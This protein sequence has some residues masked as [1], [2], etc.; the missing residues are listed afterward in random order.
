MRELHAAIVQVAV[1]SPQQAWRLWKYM[2]QK[3]ALTYETLGA[4]L[5]PSA[6]CDVVS[7]TLDASAWTSA[8]E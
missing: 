8:S 5:D 6:R 2:L 1:L 3:G 4:L 7:A